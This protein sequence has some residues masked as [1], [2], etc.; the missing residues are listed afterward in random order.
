MHQVH[1]PA[2][3]VLW[4]GEFERLQRAMEST[5]YCARRSTA[6]FDAAL[7]GAVP[8]PLRAVEIPARVVAQ[9][10]LQERCCFGYRD[11]NVSQ[12]QHLRVQP[13]RPAFEE[14]PA[15]RTIAGH[16]VQVP[17]RNVDGLR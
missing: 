12:I 7:L 6:Q 11:P 1:S 3:K 10:G 8:R 2:T 4:E 14:V 5:I 9:I 17:S 16:E 15:S 13:R